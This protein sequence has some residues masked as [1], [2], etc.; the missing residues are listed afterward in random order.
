METIF[1]KTFLNNLHEG[2]CIINKNK[3]IIFCNE[4]AQKILGYQ[5]KDIIGKKFDRFFQFPIAFGPLED[6]ISL[7]KPKEL[8]SKKRS[9]IQ[10]KP[11]IDKWNKR[12]HVFIRFVPFSIIKSKQMYMAVMFNTEM[13]GLNLDKTS[14]SNAPFHNIVGQSPKMK[15]IFN[16]IEKL[17][18]SE[19]PVLIIGES[20]T[21]KELLAKAIHKLSNRTRQSFIALDC[22]ALPL[23]LLESELF[24]YEKG[25][26]TGATNSKIG[27]LELSHKGTLFLD[28]ITEMDV[29]VQAKLLRFLQ[30]KKFRKIGGRDE[31]EVDVRLISA[32][33]KNPLD[34]INKGLF[35][36]DF[37][38]RL[39][40]VELKLPPLRER[41]E[42]I[43]FLVHHFIKKYNKQNDKACEGITES[44][45]NFLLDYDWPGNIRQLEN[46]IYRAITMSD[47]NVIN[48]QDLPDYIVGHE[49]NIFFNNSKSLR[50][51]NYK[52]LKKIYVREFEKQFLS[53][54]IKR[55]KGNITKIA[56]ES[57][58]SRVTIYRMIE[59]HNIDLQNP[60]N[61]IPQ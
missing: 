26:F 2:I 40:V 44:A 11:L 12:I 14:F 39:A 19:V 51:S 29:A 35:R 3:K 57:G 36:E 49:A 18:K 45:V 27:L 43:P 42:D 58:L 50:Y 30:E 46:T 55:H 54:L 21:G 15:V 1:Y 6:N 52:T 32:A 48:S 61:G 5:E 53:T 7:T 28:E 34:Q 20:G 17:A 23:S 37:Y 41:K 8:I 22:H 47:S 59:F 24:G 25:A 13:L 33:N 16:K 56:S 4:F 60:I 38:Y 10:L 31:K 9:T